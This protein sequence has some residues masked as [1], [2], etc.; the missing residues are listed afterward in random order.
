MTTQS[1]FSLF[2]DEVLSYCDS[3]KCAAS[4]EPS[5]VEHYGHVTTG[6][7]KRAKAVI[8]P[9]CTEDV[10]KVVQLANQ[11]NVGL[12]P[13]SAGKNWGYSDATPSGPEMVL[14]D[15][16]TM[17]K[18]LNVDEANRLA[19]IE[20]GVTQEE[21]S[22]A[23]IDTDLFMDC[24]GAPTTTSIV[25]NILDR[26]FGHTINGN[27][28]F[29]ACSFEIVLGNGE[30]LR[31]G[32][33]AYENAGDHSVKNCHTKATTGPILDGL[34]SQS[35]FGIVT[36]L[37]FWLMPKPEVILPYIVLFDSH[38][39]FLNA[40]EPIAKLKQAGVARSIM[41]VGNDMRAISSSLSY[42]LIQPL[43]DKLLSEEQISKSLSILGLGPWAMSGALY[44]SNRVIKAYKKE[45]TQNIKRH[46]ACKIHFLP[47]KQIKFVERILSMLPFKPLDKLK[48]NIK[49]A[50][51]L[52]DMHSGKP[53]DYFLKGCY[54]KH[55][56]FPSVLDEKTDIAKDGCGLIWISPTA[57]TSKSHIQALLDL[58]K[59]A[60]ES[61][62]FNLYATLS[63]I[64][65][66]STAVI[67]NPVFDINNPDETERAI[68]C[69]KQA[70]QLCI[71]NG[72][73]PYRV[74]N[75]HWHAWHSKLS[76]EHKNAL[77]A[78]KETFDPNKVIASGR[79]GIE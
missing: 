65:D 8:Q 75:V 41:H 37:C 62:G 9:E 64:D 49:S 12:Y 26:G 14:V 50:M 53:T 21:L 13:I 7:D 25:G 76:S 61:Q 74:A 18:I 22:D 29:N 67:C 63:F 78:L 5:T 44:G 32:H 79:Y 73:P 39:D 2:W 17:N 30:I 11:F 48:G 51:A 38:E 71:D 58:L 43:K 60:Y 24:T 33:L 16:S 1:K 40:I 45:L 36:K 31:T 20:P 56:N 69:T 59:N 46:S 19:I 23:L 77:S 34:F 57:P 15:L 68:V 47:G 35:N 42:Q 52:I 28:Q 55:E 27:R 6:W 70:M 72:Y 54:H 10:Q 66:R 4:I 3:R